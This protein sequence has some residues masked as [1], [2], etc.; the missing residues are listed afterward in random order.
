MRKIE[1]GRRTR[2]LTPAMPPV[3]T[4]VTAVYNGAE[5]IE[6]SIISVIGQSFPTFEYIIIDGG[7]GDS[8]VE[9]LRRYEESIEYWISEPDYG[10]YDALNKG[11]SLARG[12]W[13]YFLGAD[14]ALVDSHVLEKVFLERHDTKL[15][16]GDVLYGDTGTTYGGAF[17][18]LKLTKKNICQQGIFY[19]SDLFQT[20]GHFDLKYPLLA[21]WVFNMKVFSLRESRPEHLD[22]VVAE[23][24]LSGAS[25][26][27]LDT[28]FARDRFHMIR[29]FLGISC[30]LYAL[31]SRLQDQV[32]ANCRKYIARPTAKLFRRPKDIGR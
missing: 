29:K 3:V 32:A 10:I 24:S 13:L 4:V 2:G 12:E 11:I 7:S 31:A 18:R 26:R 1:G 30:Y 25:N 6:R 19:R 22:M 27:S 9:L 16:Y 17:T 14:D 21:D 28:Y 8:T 5:S 15:L 20:L 23:Y